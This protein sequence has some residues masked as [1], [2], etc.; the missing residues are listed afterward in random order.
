MYLIIDIA[1]YLPSSET[2]FGNQ[3]IVFTTIYDTSYMA[4]AKKED[5]DLVTGDKRLH[6]AVKGTLEWVRWLGN[7]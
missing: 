1:R 6:N 4:L 7:V 2:F 3:E 5:I